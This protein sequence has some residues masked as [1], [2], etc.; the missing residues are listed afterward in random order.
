MPLEFY[1]D[2]AGEHRWTLTADNGEILCA[3]SEGFSSRQNAQNNAMRTSLE[4]EEA[5][6]GD[7]SSVIRIA[8]ELVKNGDD[9]SFPLYQY[10]MRLSPFAFG[11]APLDHIIIENDDGEKFLSWYR[12][13]AANIAGDGAEGSEEEDDDEDKDT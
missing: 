7:D 3:A 2:S 1:K 13:D 6:H 8:V 10:F 11:V 9:E 5:L 4:L 12:I